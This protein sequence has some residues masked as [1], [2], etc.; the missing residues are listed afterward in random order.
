[1]KALIDQEPWT[2][3]AGCV[4]MPWQTWQLPAKL[5]LGYFNGFL[6]A[7]PACQRAVNIA[8]EK[9]RVAGHDVVEFEPPRVFD[10]FVFYLALVSSGGF[11]N[12]REVLGTDERDTS[13]LP[14]MNL[15]ELSALARRIF[16][17]IA[18]YW[19]KDPQ[20]A[21]IIEVT[22]A[23]STREITVLLGER[24]QYRNEF[25]RAAHESAQRQ[26]G[27]PFDA[28]ICPGFG[29]PAMPH[30][31]AMDIFY[32]FCYTA[33]HNLLDVSTGAIPVTKVDAQLDRPKDNVHGKVR[34][35][36]PISPLEQ[37]ARNYHDVDMLHGAP[38]GIQV[39][40]ER[41]TEERVLGCI[42]VIDACV[43]GKKQ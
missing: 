32:N 30:G 25:L 34:V 41:F 29:T 9:L 42:R 23:K 18:K 33:L 31:S 21:R 2:R 28:I 40:A 36:V 26:C 20:L 43:N 4:P 11:E 6:P 16:V 14:T 19:H 22:R 12:L 24:N 27:R 3:D 7:A 15:V 35:C 5:C 38:V 39:F 37:R 13:I 10:A 8:V 1:M 17:W